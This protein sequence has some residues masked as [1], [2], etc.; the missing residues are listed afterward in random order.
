MDCG[1]FLAFT[2]RSAAQAFDA[3]GERY[4]QV[5]ASRTEVERS[6]VVHPWGCDCGS[7]PFR[8]LATVA[9]AVAAG[10]GAL[11]ATLSSFLL[12]DLA[13]QPERT[14][15]GAGCTE[16]RWRWRCQIE[17]PCEAP[18]VGFLASYVFGLR[19]PPSSQLSAQGSVFSCV[20]WRSS[21]SAHNTAARVC[22]GWVQNERYTGRSAWRASLA[23]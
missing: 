9:A 22:E 6:R 23:S 14:H 3:A 17:G 5:C 16:G 15:T 7:P 4:D 18:T 21:P 20:P 12:Y 1:F 13:H 2:S 8:L 11:F 10:K 19:A